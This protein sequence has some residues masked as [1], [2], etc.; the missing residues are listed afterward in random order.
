M[1]LVSEQ[2]MNYKIDSQKSNHKSS[3]L[4]VDLHINEPARR[5]FSQVNLLNGERELR[6]EY[7]R[8]KKA[9]EEELE[10]TTCMMIFP[11]P[12][13]CFNTNTCF[14]SDPCAQWAYLGS[15]HDTLVML[16]GTPSI[17]RNINR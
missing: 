15:L 17:G 10:N 3:Y 6:T 11:Y 12:L 14:Q 9:K 4:Y 13:L 1:E 5:E 7:Q 2:E 16:V 8:K